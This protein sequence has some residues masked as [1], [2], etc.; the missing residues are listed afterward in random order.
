M[1]TLPHAPHTNTG[2]L[3][4][5]DIPM[6]RLLGLVGE[7]IGEDRARVRLPYRADLTN[8]RGDV[9]GGAFTMLFDS[10]LA[11][12][13]RAHD[14]ER[15]GVV[16]IDLVTHF[17]MPCASDVIA[18][19]WCERRGRNLCFARGE[20]R[21]TQG[22]LLAIGTGTFKLVDRHLPARTSPPPIKQP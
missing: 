18:T 15:Y 2:L 13:T 7:Y 1:N 22:E 3:F 12:A 5:S 6:A 11:C 21:D 8:S 19:A 9:H 17:L 10:V 14:P 20:A 16:T 4:G